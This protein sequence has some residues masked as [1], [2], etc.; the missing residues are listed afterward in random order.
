MH[1]A[2]HPEQQAYEYTLMPTHMRQM[3]QPHEFAGMKLAGPFSF[4][5][6]CK[7]MKLC[8]A[9]KMGDTNAFGCMLFDLQT[10]PTQSELIEDVAVETRM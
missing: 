2:L 3:F 8:G 1:A 4:T 6:G 10:D 9:D 5:K 7:V